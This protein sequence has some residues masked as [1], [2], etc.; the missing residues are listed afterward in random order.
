MSRVR[1]DHRTHTDLII[2]ARR[3]IE[4]AC[5]ELSVNGGPDPGA[6]L[7]ELFAWMSDLAIERAFRLRRQ[8]TSRQGR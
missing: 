8:R 2:E 7:I 6:T 4:A 1:L 3:R 5:P